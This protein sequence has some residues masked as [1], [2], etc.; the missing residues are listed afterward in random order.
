MKKVFLSGLALFSAAGLY[1]QSNTVSGGG[2]ATGHGGTVS[3]TV[4][5]V[6]YTAASG[7]GGS[8]SQG[9]QQVYAVSSPTNVNDLDVTLKAQIYP[10][11]TTDQLLLTL[12]GNEYKQLSYQLLDLQGKVLRQNQLNSTTT[13][14][15]VAQLPNGTYFVR[16]LDK[17]RQL[18]TFQII[19][20][21]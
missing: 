12:S 9:V 8:V 7:N 16:V 11:P 18:K 6:A 4:G 3:F 15:D 14:I 5:Q 1:A 17:Q 19:K 20:N 2:T 21:K 13:S 10:N